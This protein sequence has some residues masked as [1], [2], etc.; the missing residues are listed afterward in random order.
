MLHSRPKDKRSVGE[1]AK[2]NKNVEY[3]A[4]VIDH[5]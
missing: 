5:P 2:Q 3:C 4:K 1:N